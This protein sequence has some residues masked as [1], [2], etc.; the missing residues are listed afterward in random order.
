MLAYNTDDQ[1][2]FKVNEVSFKTSPKNGQNAQI[3]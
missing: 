1:E 3:W 2:V